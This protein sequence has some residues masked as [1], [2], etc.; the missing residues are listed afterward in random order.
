MAARVWLTLER[1]LRTS[2]HSVKQDKKCVRT[3]NMSAFLITRSPQSK[4]ERKKKKKNDVSACLNICTSGQ[5]KQAKLQFNVVFVE[6]TLNI[7]INQISHFHIQYCKMYVKFPFT[8]A[9]VFPF[10]LCE[11][12]CFQTFNITPPNLKRSNHCSSHV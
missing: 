3:Q 8:Q 7:L 9:C 12:K 2:L 6:A 5:D 11:T 10:K 4:R 1:P